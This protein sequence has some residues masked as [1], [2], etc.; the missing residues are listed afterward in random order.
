MS[1]WM[2]LKE[3]TIGKWQLPLFATSVVALAGSVVLLRPD[4]SDLPLDEA[5]DAL[6]EWS[7]L[8]RWMAES[9][10]TSTHAEA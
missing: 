3:R 1:D 5:A 10:L 7:T 6:E 4:P 8:L 9:Y 2:L